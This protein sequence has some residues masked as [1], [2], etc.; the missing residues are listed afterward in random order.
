M[1]SKWLKEITNIPGVEGVLLVSNN[2]EI[3]DRIGT[4]YERKKQEQ[5][6]LHVLRMNAIHQLGQKQVNEIEVIWDAHRIYAM[7]TGFFSVIVFCGT[8]H[9]LSLLRITVSVAIANFME[10]KKTMRLMKK[11]SSD[12][13][14]VLRSQDLDQIEINFISK[15]Q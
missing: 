1:I 3:I 13:K 14:S 8:L 11:Y 5:I 7:S 2:C 15:L 10:D 6:A 12:L 9:N 4:Q